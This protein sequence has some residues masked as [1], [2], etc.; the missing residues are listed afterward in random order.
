MG[1]MRDRSDPVSSVT[2]VVVGMDVPVVL[3][4]PTEPLL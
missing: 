4:V 2:K 1:R 3:L